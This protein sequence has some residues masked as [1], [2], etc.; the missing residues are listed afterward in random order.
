[1]K[2]KRKTLL[3]ALVS[4]ILCISL[5]AGATF[6]WFTSKNDVNI[7]VSSGKVDIVATV[8]NVKG[9]SA[10]WNEE[11]QEYTYTEKT[12]GVFSNEGTYG[13]EDG[14]LTVERITPGDG[15]TFTISVEN[16]SSVAIKYQTVVTLVNTDDMVLFK[17]LTIKVDDRNL[18]MGYATTSTNWN[19]AKPEGKINDI[20]VEIGLPITADNSAMTDK[21]GNV[22]TCNM[23]VS[24]YAIQGNANTDS[25]NDVIFVNKD[26][27]LSDIVD[28]MKDGDTLVLQDDIVVSED[29]PLNVGED[30]DIVLDVFG[31]QLE[32]E[33]NS[34]DGQT[35]T[36]GEGSS[37][38]ITDTT[39]GDE[40]GS[41]EL[42][43]NSA[44]GNLSDQA[45]GSYAMRVDGGTLNIDNVDFVIN[46]HQEA[47][48]A[49]FINGGTVN[50]DE[51]SNIEFVG[52]NDAFGIYVTSGSE[53]NINGATVHSKGVIEPFTVGNNS[54][55]E[56]SV[57]NFNPGSEM[58]LEDCGDWAAAMQVY[59][60]GVINI[61]DDTVIKVYGK[62]GN[63]QAAT[64]LACIGGGT[65]N[66][67][68]GEIIL[69]STSG[70]AYAIM[71]RDNY[72]YNEEDRG[73]PDIKPAG[74]HL[75]ANVIISGTSKI[76]ATSAYSYIFLAMRNYTMDYSDNVRNY[77]DS[78]A[79]T[80]EETVY[81]TYR[82]TEIA[83]S[84]G[85][86]ANTGGNYVKD[87]AIND[88]R[89]I[90]N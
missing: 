88:K 29:E 65:I 89:A 59:P 10:L 46:N 62:M 13:Y 48:H 8:K 83:F 6:A 60:N 55:A 86:F 85:N 43:V 36:V 20:Q 39:S 35:V 70:Y 53:M 69:D 71:T 44:S 27:S 30:K 12:D 77:L 24:V 18:G 81:I 67:M 34:E 22:N 1:M 74:Q 26:S 19:D 21:D 56:E 76:T 57:L 72:Y 5:I 66:V 47:E 79:I 32:V 4:I 23:I 73:N 38:T 51:N 42:N 17:A 90:S 84:H 14:T 11:S 2:T 82:G 9:Y 58:Y 50:V 80:I 3:T 52:S 87:K 33:K 25:L 16:K 41:F 40:R 7:A 15:V 37:L 78:Y 45:E 28:N 64:A 49:I 68:G 75:N 31:N 54:K 63:G 61:Y